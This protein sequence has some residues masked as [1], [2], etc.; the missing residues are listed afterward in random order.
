VGR[1]QRNAQIVRISRQSRNRVA[2]HLR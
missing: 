1:N 2:A